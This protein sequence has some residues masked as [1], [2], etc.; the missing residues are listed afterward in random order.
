VR[1]GVWGYVGLPFRVALAAV[2]D[3]ADGDIVIAN[4]PWRTGAMATHLCDLH[5]LKPIFVDGTLLA[6]AWAFIH[7]SDVGGAVPASIAPSLTEVYQEGLRIPPR[8]LYRA[9]VLDHDL[10]D[11]ILLNGRIPEKNR[12]DI[13]AMVSALQTGERRLKALAAKYGLSAVQDGIRDLLDY[14]EAK[15][16]AL[17]PTECTARTSPSA[18]S[19][20]RRWRASSTRSPSSSSAPTRS[21]TRPARARPGAGWRRACGS[22]CSSRRGSSR[23]AAWSG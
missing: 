15:A 6:F 10:L 12:G 4:D 1:I 22:R 19:R 20:T 14:A 13:M 3:W 17:G 8:K 16:R 18:S 21:R 23:R 7:A 5:V 11:L 2:P 9:G